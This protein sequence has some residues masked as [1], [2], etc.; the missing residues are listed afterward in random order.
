[1]PDETPILRADALDDD[2]QLEDD[3]PVSDEFRQKTA[4]F[5]RDNEKLLERL[6]EDERDALTPYQ[7]ALL[8]LLMNDPGSAKCKCGHERR[9]H[10]SATVDTKESCFSCGCWGFEPGL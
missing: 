10:G 2:L 1:M 7:R 4:E 8:T 6:A 5:I 3:E 9:D